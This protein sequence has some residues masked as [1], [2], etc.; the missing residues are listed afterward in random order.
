[1][2]K[3]SIMYEKIEELNLE[4]IELKTS[5]EYLIGK[6]ILRI[7]EYLKKMQIKECIKKINENKKISKYSH[8]QQENNFKLTKKIKSNNIPKIAVY[9]CIT[10][11]YDKEILE[12]FV[13]LENTDFYLFTD[14]EKQISE[15][16]IIKPIPENIN[17]EYNNILKNRYMKMHPYELFENYDYSIYIDGNVKV[18]SDLTELVYAINENVGIAMHKHQ[19]RDCICDEIEVCKIKKKGNYKEMKRQVEKYVQNGFPKKFGMLEATIIVT[20]LK[21]KV[22]KKILNDWWDEFISTESLRDQISL[23]YIVWKNKLKI[24]DIGV[25]GNNLYRNPKFRINIH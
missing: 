2:N 13:K 14:N 4:T 21:N 18:M 25:L 6:K 19:F 11:N 15:N 8:K 24:D 16:W 17:R 1:M 10:G 22:A 23:Q 9:T 5:K 20:D 7:K 3:E 12:P